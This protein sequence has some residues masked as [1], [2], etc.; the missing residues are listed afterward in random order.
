MSQPSMEMIRSD[1]VSE[2]YFDMQKSKTH[3]VNEVSDLLGD[4]SFP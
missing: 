3:Q 1:P 2:N 4:R